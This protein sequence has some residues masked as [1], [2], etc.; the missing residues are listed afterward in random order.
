[1]Q[2]LYCIDRY[3]TNRNG[4]VKELKPPFTSFRNHRQAYGFRHFQNY[5]TRV[6]VLCP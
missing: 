6:K 3:L 1:M 4:N 5:R 2:I